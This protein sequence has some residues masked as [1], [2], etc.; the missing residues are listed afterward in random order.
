MYIKE[1]VDIEREIEKYEIMLLLLIASESPEWMILEKEEKLRQ[2]RMQQ[3]VS[4]YN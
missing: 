1:S 4:H 3:Y 2:L